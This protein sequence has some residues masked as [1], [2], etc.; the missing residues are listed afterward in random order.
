MSDL[1]ID[2]FSAAS[3]QSIEHE[4]LLI[5]CLL[6]R[7]NNE[8]DGTEGGT[9]NVQPAFASGQDS[10]LAS[11]ATNGTQMI[12]CPFGC[13]CQLKQREPSYQSQKI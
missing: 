12:Q 9:P 5:T 3:K 6:F 2:V 7:Y 10:F 13:V 1:S 4:A 11:L 8:N